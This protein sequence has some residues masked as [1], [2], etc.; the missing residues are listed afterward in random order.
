MASEG[1]NA[2]YGDKCGFSSLAVGQV[3]P[4]H[5]GDPNFAI[6]NQYSIDA[7][8]ANNLVTV[9]LGYIDVTNTN[10]ADGGR[11]FFV[12]S[13]VGVNAGVVSIL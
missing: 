11:A 5:E 13:T 3:I 6:Y 2:Q 4:G 9:N 10:N 1:H 8:L 7:Q 12:P